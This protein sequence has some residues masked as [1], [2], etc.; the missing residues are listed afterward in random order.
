MTTVLQTEFYFNGDDDM[1]RVDEY[2]P[3]GY[4]PVHIGGTFP[5]RDNPRHRVFHKGSDRFQPSGSPKMLQAAAKNCWRV[6]KQPWYSYTG[7]TI[8]HQVILFRSGV[9][10]FG[11]V[12]GAD[13]VLQLARGSQRLL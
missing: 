6:Q 12:A 11:D 3:G 5:T 2:K 13:G 7:K 4:H 8:Q 1:E 10:G 9:S